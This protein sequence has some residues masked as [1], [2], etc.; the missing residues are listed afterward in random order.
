MS[1]RS[2]PLALLSTLAASLA[3]AAPP[4]ATPDIT[5]SPLD[6]FPARFDYVSN[7]AP[8][9]VFDIA[10]RSLV[11]PAALKAFKELVLSFV[12]TDPLQKVDVYTYVVP[13]GGKPREAPTRTACGSTIAGHYSCSIP[14]HEALLLLQG[15]NGANGGEGLFGLRVEAEG[16]EGERSTVRITLPVKGG[17]AK[18]PPAKVVSPLG[19][20]FLAARP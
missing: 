9:V 11:G 6:S 8:F 14:T 2:I 7:N 20:S 3:L 13:N 4:A 5:S 1:R 15:V 18:P 17:S 10:P 19:L 16:I 12:A